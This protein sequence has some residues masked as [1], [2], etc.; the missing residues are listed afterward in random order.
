M[1]FPINNVGENV[2]ETMIKLNN[3]QKN[4]IRI[5]KLDK[6]ITQSEISKKLNKTIRTVERNM[7]KL[8]EAK[9]IAR[10]GSDTAGYWD[11][12]HKADE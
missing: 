4:I 8:Q 11:V 2:G 1:S 7:K 12:I 9:I 5:I 3:T 6:Y 10:I